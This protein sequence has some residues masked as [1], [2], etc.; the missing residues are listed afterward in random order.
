MLFILKCYIYLFHR[1]YFCVIFCSWCSTWTTRSC[2]ETWTRITRRPTQCSKCT[3]RRRAPSTRRTATTWPICK[4]PAVPPTKS[5]F[6]QQ[7][8]AWFASTF[9]RSHCAE[10]SSDLTKCHIWLHSVVFVS[11]QLLF[12][13]ILTNKSKFLLVISIVVAH[14]RVLLQ[15]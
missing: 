1:E 13:V 11:S 9:L 5:P 2:S 10:L 3:R 6:D 14:N 15:S 12:S 7:V 8:T 4:S